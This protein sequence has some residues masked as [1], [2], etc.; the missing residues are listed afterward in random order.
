MRPTGRAARVRGVSHGKQ[1]AL[2]AVRLARAVGA[3]LA[4][5]VGGPDPP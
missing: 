2:L 4:E 5:A 1:Q 3:E